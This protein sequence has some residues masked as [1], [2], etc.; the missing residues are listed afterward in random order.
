MPG[1]SI[2]SARAPVWRKSTALIW[3]KATCLP[4]GSCCWGQQSSAPI[5]CPPLPIKEAPVAIMRGLENLWLTQTSCLDSKVRSPSVSVRSLTS[6]L[7]AAKDLR[8]FPF[9]C[10]SCGAT[11]GSHEEPR[12][13]LCKHSV[14]MKHIIDLL[15]FSRESMPFDLL[16]LLLQ[17]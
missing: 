14:R 5:M 13:D 17:Q 6:H 9:V 4:D 10:D 7:V 1:E 16:V 12:R 15:P 11:G 2:S 8:P 3:P